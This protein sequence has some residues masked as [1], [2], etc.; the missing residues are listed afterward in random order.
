M[1]KIRRNA[2]VYYHTSDLFQKRNL[3]QDVVNNMRRPENY[4]CYY[5][6]CRQV[7]QFDKNEDPEDKIDF[8]D[9]IDILKRC[10]S[11]DPDEIFFSEYMTRISQPWI[12][13]GTPI[14]LNEERFSQE[15]ETLY[16]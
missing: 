3:I 11:V 1:I 13:F 12:V 5:C 16:K 4:D 14:W 8:E 6:I 9:F 15:Y 2:L 10:I 7:L